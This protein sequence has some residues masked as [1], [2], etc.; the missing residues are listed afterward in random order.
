MFVL[1]IGNQVK[2][3]STQ[4]FLGCANGP[5]QTSHFKI[6]QKVE[7]LENYLRYMVKWG[8]KMLSSMSRVQRYITLPGR[9]LPSG[10]G[11]KW[12]GS[13]RMWS[14]RIS[15][16]SARWAESNDISHLGVGGWE[17]LWT[18]IL[19]FTRKRNFINRSVEKSLTSNHQNLNCR[20]M[21]N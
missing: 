1:C 9:P 12:S 17:P 16:C 4:W 8:I 20:K 2:P 5:L 21:Y 13:G 11:Q 14:S 10:V 15:K 18:Q 3:T 6:Y 7:Y 19:P